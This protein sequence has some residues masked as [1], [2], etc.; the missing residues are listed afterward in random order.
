MPKYR[1]IVSLLA[2]AAAGFAALSSQARAAASI[3]PAASQR[4]SV[5]FA[6]QSKRRPHVII[7]PRHVQLDPSAKRICRA[8]LA[9]EYR[10]SGTVITPQMQCWWQQ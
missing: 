4:H 6:A 5:E 8:W 9:Q 10:P 2:L 7:R 1:F 3:G